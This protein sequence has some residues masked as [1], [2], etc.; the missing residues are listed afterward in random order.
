MGRKRRSGRPIN[1]WINVDKPVGVTSAACVNR[2]RRA[3]DA[4]KLGHAGTLDPA[5][6]GVL[7]VA[8]GEATKTMPYVV[9]S[10]KQYAFTINWGERRDTDD[11]Q[12]RVVETADGRPSEAEIRAALP[13]FTGDI[14]QVPPAYSA[15]KVDG[16]RA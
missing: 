7:P 1:G 4:A 6:S 8:L 11:D 3:L 10:N 14:S 12:G 5:A 9:N 15:I 2:V 16:A 13:N